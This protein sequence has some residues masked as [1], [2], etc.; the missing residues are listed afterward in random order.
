M[1]QFIGRFFLLSIFS[2][3]FLG[4]FAQ[5]TAIEIRGTVI[6]GI[7]NQPIEYATVLIENPENNNN[8][9]GTS[10]GPDGSFLLNSE[11]SDFVIE[12]SFIGFEKQVF[13]D[14][15]I[16]NGLLDL[17]TI[18]LNENSQAL[19]EVLIRAE[20]ST[21]EFKLDKRVFNVG[22]DLSNTGASVLEVL[23]NVPS[24]DVNIEGQISLRG[25]TGVQILINGKP[26]VLASEEGNALGSITAEM[27]EKIEVITNPSAKYEAEG[28]SGI[29]N[30]VI[31]KEEKKGINGSVTLNTGYPNNH[32]LGL[33]MNR[34]TE[35]FN[36]FTQ[37]GVGYRTFP[38]ESETINKNL[39]N[40]TSIFSN[41]SSEK[42]ETFYNLILGTDYHINNYNVLTLSGNYAFE[43]EDEFSDVNFE[44]F[45]DDELLLSSWDRTEITSAT[46]PK[47]QYELQYKKDFKDNKEHDL[48]FS[49]LGQFFGKDRN[50]DF[51][52]SIIEGELESEEQKTQSFFKNADYTFKL[53]YTKPFLE[54]YTLESGAQYQIKD[55]R[56]DYSVQDLMGEEWIGNPDLTNIFDFNQKVL[57]VYGTAAYEGKKWGIKSGIRYEYTELDTYLENNEKSN[58]TNYGNWF[59]S[60]HTSYKINKRFSLQAGYSKRIYRP[61]MWSLNPFFNIRNTFSIRTGNPD[62]LPEFTDSYELTGIYILGKSSFNLGV[63]RRNTSDV[64]ERVITFEDN[65][66]ITKPLNIGTETTT[67]LEFNMKYNP[68]KWV[69]INGDLN[70]TYYSREGAFEGATFDFSSDRWSSKVTTKFKFP[71]DHDLE[72]SGRYQSGRQTF[73]SQISGILYADIGFRKKFKNGRTIVNISVRDVFASRERESE[74][75]Q[76][77]YYLYSRYLRGRNITVG[78]SY[79][80]GKGEAMEFS[81]HKR[82]R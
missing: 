22:K 42:N 36:L 31:K 6:E 19:E 46:N 44:S 30:I 2:F 45:Y 63:F 15:E 81:G 12:V 29:I 75:I 56:N 70:Y 20:R 4:L 11:L 32:S 52:N 71:Y 47:W 35:K 40:N 7:N 1:K 64:I 21:T 23:N 48:L 59:P 66:S 73:Q 49:A 72:I 24:V 5:G 80:F 60:L 33:S 14:F 43:K 82:W 68:A 55:V 28:T 18:I 53:D 17:G 57:G 74:S 76:D 13:D 8:I 26:S 39:V 61:R 77:D 9:S 67:G 51:T 54:N 3:M 65:V 50:S 69:T 41:G 58:K 34:R 62:L 25:S 16:E 78:I 79:G 27:V 10:T 38:Y 37:L